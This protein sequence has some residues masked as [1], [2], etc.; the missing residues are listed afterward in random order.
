MLVNLTP[1]Y[2]GVVVLLTYLT[3]IAFNALFQVLF[4]DKKISRTVYGGTPIVFKHM[5]MDLDI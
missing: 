4:S 2:Y 5:K 3:K 1:I